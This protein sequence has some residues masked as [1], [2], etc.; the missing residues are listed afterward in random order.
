MTRKMPPKASQEQ[1]AEL[2]R[3]LVGGQVYTQYDVL[4][5][6]IPM[7]FMPLAFGGL[8]GY[9]KQQLARIV[10]W[11]SYPRH[12]TSGV[13]CNGFP[14]FVECCIWRRTDFVTAIK[15]AEK[16]QAVLGIKE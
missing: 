1:I 5:N 6:D 7:V 2:A 10:V 14:M 4:P 16:A 8:R 13:F 12:K 11:G 3:D 9:T 15:L